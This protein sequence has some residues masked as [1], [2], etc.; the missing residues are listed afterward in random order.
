M[1]LVRKAQHAR[2]DYVPYLPQSSS[3]SRRMAQEAEGA[4]GRLKLAQPTVR[5]RL[6]RVR[7]LATA[8]RKPPMQWISKCLTALAFA[9]LFSSIANASD[10]TIGLE[11][12]GNCIPFSCQGSHEYQQVYS[13]SPFLVHGFLDLTAVSF[14]VEGASLA[15]GSGNSLTT[16]TFDISLST[17]SMN[18][19]ALDLNFVN[20]IGADNATVFSGSFSVTNAT[21]HERI[22]LSFTN[23]F[24]YDPTLGN[25]LLT[26][27]STVGFTPQNTFALSLF[28]EIRRF[29]YTLQQTDFHDF[30]HGAGRCRSCYD[31][32]N[33]RQLYAA[34]RRSPTVRHRPRW[35]R[36]ARLAQE[37]ERALLSPPESCAHVR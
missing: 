16:P 24:F 25:L 6:N 35:I 14:Y 30:H 1:P 28:L 17:T 2:L 21:P 20:N 29:L 34:S 18:V 32:L 7:Y 19:G 10:I 12:N 37:A 22:F 13:N 33:I 36:S 3:A 26:I 4:S 27:T 15:L 5:I 9:S 11:D 23:P 31:L 8:R